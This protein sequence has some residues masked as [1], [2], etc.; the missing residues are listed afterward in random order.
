ME[1][2]A[3]VV[4]DVGKTMS[5]LSLWTADGEPICR[6]ARPNERR[7]SG[8]FDVL[9][10][11]GITPWVI[12]T[13]KSFSE[14][15]IIT[16]IIPVAHGAALAVVRDGKLAAQPM[17]Y[18]TSLPAHIAEAYAAERDAFSI[19][20]SPR[21]SE[22]LNAGAQLYWQER[23]IPDLLEGATLMPWAQYWAWFLS[24]VDRAEVT[25]LGCH[26]DLW[27]PLRSDY[28]PMA[29]RMGWA[30]AFAPKA[31][32]G[33]AIGTLRSELAEQTGLSQDVKIYCGIHDSNAALVAARAHDEMAEGDRTVLS[34]GTWFV[35]MRTPATP[36]NI[37]TLPLDRDCLLNV[38]AWSDAIP[39]ARFMGG[40]EI[41][42]LIGIDTRRVDIKPDQPALLDAV[43][44]L[45]A[46]GRM[47]QPSFAKGFGPYPNGR[48]RWI[49]MPEDWFARRSGACL[50]AAMLATTSLDLIG[51]YQT[52]LVEGRFAEAE[53]IVRALASLRPNDAIYTCHA[54]ND[55]SFG[56]LKLINP[57]LKPN[58]KLERVKPLETDLTGYFRDWKRLAEKASAIA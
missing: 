8:D 31:F 18:E 54:Q 58:T 11:E 24:G 6:E 21:L 27:D 29:K 25:S 19:S 22:G 38:D 7:S 37:N 39:S 33:N 4:L 32:A 40:R 48:G 47:L 52:I 42:T 57:M 14:Q 10:V 28:S 30:S 2:N 49:D 56:A 3:I 23:E 41:E 50:Y 17:D 51:S 9:D 36:F 53:V 55:V 16:K 13:L 35:A 43:P 12:D 34:T 45:V 15:A 1:A 44:G 5:K 26:T 46:N 20:G